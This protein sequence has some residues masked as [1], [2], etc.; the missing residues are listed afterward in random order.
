[1]LKDGKWPPA[2]APTDTG[3]KAITVLDLATSSENFANSVLALIQFPTVAEFSNFL[4]RA[5][6]HPKIHRGPYTD[7]NTEFN[8]FQVNTLQSHQ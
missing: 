8:K 4:A 7:E 3:N 2:K 1:M 5:I 6:N